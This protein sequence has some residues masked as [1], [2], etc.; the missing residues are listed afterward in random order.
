MGGKEEE[1]RGRKGMMAGRESWK[2]GREGRLG[3][4]LTKS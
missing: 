4:T 3:P 2:M 1:K